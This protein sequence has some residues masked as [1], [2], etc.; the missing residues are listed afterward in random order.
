[1][2][3]E[4]VNFPALN[5]QVLATPSFRHRI[6]MQIPHEILR[7]TIDFCGAAFYVGGVWEKE[8]TIGLDPS[9][10]RAG[11]AVNKRRPP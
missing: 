9:R 3:H 5:C 2:L 10:L 4:M 7:C 8:R 1:M 11:R 6:V